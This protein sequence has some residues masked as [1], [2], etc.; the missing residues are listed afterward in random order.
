MTSEI[1]DAIVAKDGTGQYKTLA[2][3]VG[4]IPKDF[5]GR[6]VIL[7]KGGVYHENVEITANNV[8]LIGGRKR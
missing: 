4:S 3:A 6:Y 7:L 8:T 5:P 1:P 2:E